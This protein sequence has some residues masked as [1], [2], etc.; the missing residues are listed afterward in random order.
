[1]SIDQIDVSNHEI[2]S[3]SPID[4]SAGPGKKAGSTG[5][6]AAST[7]EDSVALSSQARTIDQL[8]DLAGNDRT[9]RMEQIKAAIENGAYEVAGEAIAQKIIDANQK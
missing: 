9:K 2:E 3:N 4:R 1:M 6:K 8:T 5:A 7:G